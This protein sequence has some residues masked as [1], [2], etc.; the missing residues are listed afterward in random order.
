MPSTVLSVRIPRD[1]FD[2]LSRVAAVSGKE[3]SAIVQEAL[4]L[5]FQWY[6]L[7]IDEWERRT[8]T[9]QQR[10]QELIRYGMTVEEAT[11]TLAL[12][13]N[14]D[15][16]LNILVTQKRKAGVSVEDLTPKELKA[17]EGMRQPAA[18]G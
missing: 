12:V 15:G 17:L 5:W 8:K 4:E 18:V 7:S 3:K 16:W 1:T 11:R 2:S 6:S 14:E 9:W 13:K 10:L